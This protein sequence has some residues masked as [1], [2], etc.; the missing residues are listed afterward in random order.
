MRKFRRTHVCSGALLAMTL[1]AMTLT[2][3]A[4]AIDL[5]PYAIDLQLDV[6][7]VVVDSPY[8]SSVHGGL[9]QLRFDETHD[10]LRLGRL[11]ANIAGPI[12]DTVRADVTLSGTGDGDKHALDAT[13]AFL[14][15]RPYPRSR[16]RLRT[17]A[18]AFY[19]PISMENRAVGWQSAYSISASG[20]NTWISEEI[21]TIGLEQSMTL[22]SASRR[23]F[24]VGLVAGAYKWND[25]AGVLLFQRGW[26]LHDRQS[27]LFGEL[28]RPFSRTDDDK[29]IEFFREIDGRIGYYAGGELKYANRH[30]LR[31][32]HY[33]NR[34]DPSIRSGKD[35]AW[36]TRFNAVGWRSELTTDTTLIVQGL[37]GD[38]SVGASADG[39]GALV[40]EYW[41]YFA[42]ASQQLGEHRLTAR[43][44][45]LY[46]ESERG[47][48][49]FNSN[50]TAIAW[51]FAYL[52]DLNRSWQLALE[53][54]EIRGAL[55]QRSRVGLAPDDVER[56]WQLAARYSL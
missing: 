5:G 4:F 50:Q 52:W 7:G 35:S 27:P 17:R 10:G 12:T 49:T 46:T 32:L 34:G 33:D 24:D 54:L 39:R 14:E 51:T 30:G 31:A 20:I 56:S 9:G 6:R 42:L 18:G 37:K 23:G 47:A 15:W 19:P 55:Q 28:P 29:T 1:F 26:A 3:R 11:L 36:L 25:P 44:D 21:R 40:V 22:V 13:E 48:S 41:S 2:A 53:M 8:T 38:T 45:R 16:L 43:Y